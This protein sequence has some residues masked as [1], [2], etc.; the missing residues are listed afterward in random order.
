V[1][2][3]VTLGNEKISEITYSYDYD[4]R[5]KDWERIKF[6]HYPDIFGRYLDDYLHDTLASSFLS[7]IKGKY[8]GAKEK[9]SKDKVNNTIN[10]LSRIDPVWWHSDKYKDI[11]LKK[12][13]Q[14]YPDCVKKGVQ[15]ASKRSARSG[16]SSRITQANKKRP[17]VITHFFS[18]LIKAALFVLFLIILFGFALTYFAS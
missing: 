4:D 16:A 3:D 6:I 1:K 9:P 14:L 8:R 18:S 17:N 10:V 5:L 12:F 2:K 7:S 11:F 15:K 13:A